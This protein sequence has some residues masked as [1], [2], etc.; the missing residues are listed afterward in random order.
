MRNG[1]WLKDSQTCVLCHFKCAWGLPGNILFVDRSR[2]ICDVLRI[3]EIQDDMHCFLQV[4]HLL[5]KKTAVA[6]ASAWRHY[7][8]SPLHALESSLDAMPAPRKLFQVEDPGKQA[9]AVQDLYMRLALHSGRHQ[10]HACAC[11][12]GCKRVHDVSSSF[13]RSYI[14]KGLCA[15]LRGVQRSNCK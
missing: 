2:S 14:R 8:Q 11:A 15:F 5:Q 10:L 4:A 13:L 6:Q 7:N 9:R 12:R 1:R 3:I